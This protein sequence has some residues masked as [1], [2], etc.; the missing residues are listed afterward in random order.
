MWKFIENLKKDIK[1]GVDDL[2]D[3]QESKEVRDK[4][5][6]EAF[7]L[8]KKSIVGNDVVALED[9]TV[10][11]V[12]ADQDEV[13]I[14]FDNGTGYSIRFPFGPTGYQVKVSPNEKVKKGQVLVSFGPELQHNA[15]V[16]S[17]TPDMIKVLTESRYRIR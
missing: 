3:E 17:F 5:A 16:Y 11:M 12:N 14:Y 6:D 8:G 13:E 4:T 15:K 9:G 2:A 10:E 7:E 1:E